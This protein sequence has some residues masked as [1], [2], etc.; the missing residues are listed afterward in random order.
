MNDT[1][2]D[3]ANRAKLL[4]ETGQLS[5]EAALLVEQLLKE[6]E[7]VNRQNINLRKA[8][9]KSSSKQARMSS[10]LKDALME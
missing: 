10:K 6:L 7:T 9:L 5:P 2:A 3:L 1:V 8:A 4:K